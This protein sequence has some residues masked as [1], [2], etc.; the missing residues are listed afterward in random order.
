MSAVMTLVDRDCIHVISDAAF[1]DEDGVLTATAPKVL[2]VP[3][4]NAV[5]ASRGPASAYSAILTALEEADYVDFDNLRRQIESIAQRCDELLDGLP[6]ELIVAGW[7]DEYSCGQVLFR[8]THSAGR[9]DVEAGVTYLMGDRA[10]FGVAIAHAWD[11]DEVL[12]RFEDARAFSD[13]IAC[14]RG[15]NP[16]MGFSVGGYVW[17]AVIRPETAPAFEIMREWPDVIGEKIN[18]PLP[19][20]A[21]AA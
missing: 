4:A 7:S 12:M 8:Q 21:V 11:R 17:H 10:G 3:G 15:D 16:I 18:A 1:Y 5:F 13:D 14:G 2:P 9:R 6:F 20:M 19:A